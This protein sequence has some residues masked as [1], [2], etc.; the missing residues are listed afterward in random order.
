MFKSE[1]HLSFYFYDP[2]Y[3][4]RG[5]KHIKRHMDNQHKILY[6]EIS[7]KLLHKGIVESTSGVF[8]LI[9]TL[10]VNRK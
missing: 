9:Y 6:S 7:G 10:G 8:S 5:V 3:L 2:K 1:L 4:S